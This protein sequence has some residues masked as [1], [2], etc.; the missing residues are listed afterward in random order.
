MYAM[1]LLCNATKVPNLELR[2]RSKH[3]LGFPLNDTV[4]LANIKEYLQ[5][6]EPWVTVL[7]VF[8]TLALQSRKGT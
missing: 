6:I 4:L 3:L 7:K 8:V 1:H 2:T 5:L